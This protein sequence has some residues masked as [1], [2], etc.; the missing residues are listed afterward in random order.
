MKETLLEK[1]ICGLGIVLFGVLFGY[2]AA[3]CI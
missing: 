2:V 1:A 3:G